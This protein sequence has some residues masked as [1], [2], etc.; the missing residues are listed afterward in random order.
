M[1]GTA[2]LHQRPPDGSDPWVAEPKKAKAP[3]AKAAAKDKSKGPD[4][5]A[6]REL[7][8]LAGLGHRG[9]GQSGVRSPV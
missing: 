6:I 3:A 5:D 9:P 8:A 4:E 1:P 7:D 2:R